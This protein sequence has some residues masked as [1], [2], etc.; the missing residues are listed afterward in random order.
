MINTNTKLAYLIFKKM[1]NFLFD[2][3]QILIYYLIIKNLN[4]EFNLLAI[5]KS[6]N[7]FNF[8]FLS[9]LYNSFYNKFK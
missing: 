8:L 7:M 9:F 6:F 5:I 4:Y 1:F 2:Y 3:F